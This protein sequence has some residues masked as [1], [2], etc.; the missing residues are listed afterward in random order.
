MI[1]EKSVSDLETVK[2]VINNRFGGLANFIKE[3]LYDV[4]TDELRKLGPGN[5]QYSLI[6]RA[7]R[8]MSR[9]SSLLTEK[10]RKQLQRVLEM[11]ANLNQVYAMKQRLQEIWNKSSVTQDN[12]M[13]ALQEWCRVAESSG[14]EALREF[15]RRLRRYELVS[16]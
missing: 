15:S 12:L 16:P 13:S 10:S 2:A 1:K 9:E 4:C 6:K 5:R 3:V 8:L 11:N 14:I 7:R